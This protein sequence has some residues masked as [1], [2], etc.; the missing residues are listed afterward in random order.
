MVMLRNLTISLGFLYCGLAWSTEVK[1]YDNPIPAKELGRQLFPHRNQTQTRS[2]SFKAKPDVSEAPQEMEAAKPVHLGL[3]INFAYN[4]ASIL[5]E[6]EEFIDEVG[7]MLTLEEYA[8]QKLVIEGHTDAAGTEAYN[9]A[10]SQRRA[11]SVKNFL[12]THYQIAPERLAT[13]GLGEARLLSDKGPYAA[14]NR[15]VEFYR[16]P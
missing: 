2:I 5:P 6:S 10:L 8:Q 1:I 4:S 15:R 16:A 14:A 9:L 12:V 3:L 7:K 13:K 11:E